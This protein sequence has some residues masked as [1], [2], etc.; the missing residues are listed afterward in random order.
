MPVY[1]YRCENCGV[2]FE[3]KQSFNEATLTICPECNKKS[4]KKVYAPVGVVFKG[5]GWYATDHRSPSGSSRSA[6]PESAASTSETTP[7]APAAPASSEKK[8]AT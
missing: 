8:S 5:S 1:A 2:R 4:L 7:A 3:R 6:K